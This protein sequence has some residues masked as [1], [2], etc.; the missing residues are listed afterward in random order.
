MECAFGTLHAIGDQ[1]KVAARTGGL[2]IVQ[3]RTDMPL[4]AGRLKC[5]HDVVSSEKM[6]WTH[7]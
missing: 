5:V 2:G 7:C 4:C 6:R 3:G 1:L